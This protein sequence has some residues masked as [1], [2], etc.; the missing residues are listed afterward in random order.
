MRV[1]KKEK[2]M[3]QASGTHEPGEF[4]FGYTRLSGKQVQVWVSLVQVRVSLVQVWVSQVQVIPAPL[5]FLVTHLHRT[6][7]KPQNV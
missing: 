6:I 7:W 3:G 5:P 1:G 2:S 4:G